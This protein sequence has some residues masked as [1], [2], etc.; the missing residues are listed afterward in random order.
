L[1]HCVC[2]CVLFLCLFDCF[3]KEKKNVVSIKILFTPMTE[4]NML[5][6]FFYKQT[7]YHL[8]ENTKTLKSLNNNNKTAKKWFWGGKK[9]STSHSCAIYIIYLNFKGVSPILSV[10]HRITNSTL[11]CLR[12][13][14]K[15]IRKTKLKKK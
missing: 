9:K 4:R 11:Y 10:Q 3:W 6:V 12:R 8:L 14:I 1:F 2:V 7:W 13:K 15:R 5:G